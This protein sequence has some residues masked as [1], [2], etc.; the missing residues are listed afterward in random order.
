MRAVGALVMWPTVAE[1]GTDQVPPPWD[2]GTSGVHASDR[3]S[4]DYKA[5]PPAVHTGTPGRTAATPTGT[6][7]ASTIALGQ[8]GDLRPHYP[9]LPRPAQRAV[10]LKLVVKREKTPHVDRIAR[11]HLSC[12]R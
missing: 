9:L 5:E 4:S 6:H 10:T 8:R 3:E 12:G 2:R 11:L 1:L 7:D